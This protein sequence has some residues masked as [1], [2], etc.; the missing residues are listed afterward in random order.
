MVAGGG[1]VLYPERERREVGDDG[2]GA[3][4]AATAACEREREAGQA[5][6]RWPSGVGSRPRAEVH[7]WLGLRAGVRVLFFLQKLPRPNE[8]KQNPKKIPR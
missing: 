6:E 3:L 4:L 2:G 8:T 5:S 7:G 1:L